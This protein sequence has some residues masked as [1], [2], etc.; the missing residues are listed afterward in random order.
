MSDRPVVSM[1]TVVH[2]HRLGPDVFK[3][4][5]LEHDQFS[6]RSGEGSDTSITN[7]VSLDQIKHLHTTLDA[8][9]QDLSRDD[10]RPPAAIESFVGDEEAIDAFEN[11]PGNVGLNTEL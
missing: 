10:R 2:L 3:V 4:M 7:V 1:V 8:L 5:Q 9:L 11:D 6:V